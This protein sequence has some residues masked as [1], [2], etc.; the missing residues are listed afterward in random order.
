[1]TS[2]RVERVVDG[3][4][5]VLSSL[6]KTRLI[7]MNTPETVAPAQ[8]R[9]APPDCYGPEASAKTKQLLP[10]GTAVNI[11]L[12]K[13]PQDK[14][15]RSLAYVYVAKDGAF[16]NGDLVKSGFARAKAYPPN[17][18]YKA[19]FSA[20]EAEAKAEGRGLWG[21]CADAKPTSGKGFDPQRATASAPAAAKP[22][23]QPKTPA[24]RKQKEAVARETEFPPAAL[25]NPG[26][27]KNCADFRSYAEARE[28]YDRYFP[29]FGD[30]AK[31]DGNGDGIPCNG[32]YDKVK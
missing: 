14:F 11:E 7:G 4:T 3:D 30:V 21:S 24:E 31:L 22:V 12:D 10:V 15:G 29:R 8:R 19:Q 18:R 16:V 2:D 17:V 13:E 25:D 27:V 20:L 9:G 32:L 23:Q 5:I 26:D 6:G 1:M 28:W